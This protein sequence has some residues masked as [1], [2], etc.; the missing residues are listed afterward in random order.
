MQDVVY[1][2]DTGSGWETDEDIVWH[3]DEGNAAEWAEGR[4]H[5]FDDRCRCVAH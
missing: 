2:I 4:M 1:V 3:V 5:L